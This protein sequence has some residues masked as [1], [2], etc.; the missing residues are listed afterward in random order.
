METET[1]EEVQIKK[2]N[3]VRKY[4]DEELKKRR[5]DRFKNWYERKKQD[6]YLNDLKKKRDTEGYYYH[7]V[8]NPNSKLNVIKRLEQEIENLKKL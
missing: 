4:T 5:A 2:R 8:K 6:G 3:R 1:I 7:K